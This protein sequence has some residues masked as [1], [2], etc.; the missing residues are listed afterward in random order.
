MSPLQTS[1][2]F[3]QLD[4]RNSQEEVGI[5]LPFFEAQPIPG[6]SS[7]AT[8]HAFT[9]NSHYSRTASLASSTKDSVALASGCFLHNRG[10][11]P[12]VH[13][14]P[15]NQRDSQLAMVPLPSTSFPHLPLV[16]D[17]N[18]ASFL[19]SIVT[20]PTSRRSSYSS[21]AVQRRAHNDA[22]PVSL[23]NPSVIR[24][25]TKKRERRMSKAARSGQKS[26]SSSIASC[27]KETTQRSPMEDQIRGSQLSLYKLFGSSA[28]ASP[29]FSAARRKSSRGRKAQPETGVTTDV[30][31]NDDSFSYILHREEEETA[32]RT[33]S[34]VKMI[35]RT[36]QEVR[37]PISVDSHR[38]SDSALD[39]GDASRGNSRGPSSPAPFNETSSAVPSLFSESSIND[40]FSGIL[41]V[42]DERQGKA[43]Q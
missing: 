10:A 17:E 9:H 4:V 27:T 29:I 30:L 21:L 36:T 6:V 20:D 8:P 12:S 2:I 34:G 28:A 41:L 3:Q 38:R 32:V 39:R 1:G 25:L 18:N 14:A 35:R 22:S 33:K 42:G 37:L 24:H 13:C 5:R 31:R 7:L 19:A 15:T 16:G 43:D 40:M 11:R 26:R 23:G